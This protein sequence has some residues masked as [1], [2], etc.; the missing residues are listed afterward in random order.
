MLN[1]N[2]WHCYFV[3]GHFFFLIRIPISH[4][5][6][7][8]QI[9]DSHAVTTSTHARSLEQYETV[10]KSGIDNTVRPLNSVGQQAALGQYSKSVS[11][12]MTTSVTSSWYTWGKYVSDLCPSHLTGG[13]VSIPVL[14]WKGWR[15][16]SVAV[17]RKNCCS[18]SISTW[19]VPFYDP[20]FSFF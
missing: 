19:H 6:T 1:G 7:L 5:D 16:N 4:V 12:R 11:D 2:G 9:C 13:S 20:L 10:Y 17:S 14:W 18:F 8:R 3:T 15:H